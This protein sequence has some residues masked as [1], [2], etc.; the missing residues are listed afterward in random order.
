MGYLLQ[1]GEGKKTN[2]QDPCI[3]IID[4]DIILN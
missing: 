1:I 2:S 4:S 3:D